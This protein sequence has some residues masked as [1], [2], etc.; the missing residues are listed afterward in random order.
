MFFDILR[1][2][3]FNKK[4]IDNLLNDD[5]QFFTP[6]MINRWLSF[7]SN[8]K[9]IFTNEILNKFGGIFEDKRDAFLFYN[10]VIPVSK[11]KKINYVKKKKEK[12]ET[13]S[14]TSRG[15]LLIM[16]RNNHISKREVNMYMDLFNKS[17]I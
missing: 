6:F 5:L 13:D 14:P 4:N 2:L 11:F 10:E 9:A 17:T 7:Y 8:S 16:A 15:D 12:E 3:L 1:T